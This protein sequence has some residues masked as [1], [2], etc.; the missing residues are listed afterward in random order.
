MSTAYLRDTAISRIDCELD[1]LVLES[2]T[3]AT[4][5]LP[6]RLLTRIVSTGAIDWSSAALASCMRKA[7]P[8]ALIDS[9]GK[10]IG[11]ISPASQT[12]LSS[13]AQL[14]NGLKHL[15]YAADF[16]S[17]ASSRE[18]FAMLRST[19]IRSIMLND[20]RED[21]LWELMHTKLDQLYPSLSARV[22]DAQ[23][24]GLCKSWLYQ[25]LTTAGLSRNIVLRSLNRSE[26]TLLDAFNNS[27]R[28]VLRSRYSHWMYSASGDFIPEFAFEN[29]GRRLEVKLREELA[30]LSDWVTEVYQQNGH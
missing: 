11:Y 18:R 5:Y 4:R 6:L 20:L 12:P 19:K 9:H 30:A 10:N 17:W 1:A 7:I 15:P 28:W 2:R 16:D 25:E 26:A 13:Y 27:I 8:I 24:Q 22:I 29:T 3:K 21:R 23:M 14:N